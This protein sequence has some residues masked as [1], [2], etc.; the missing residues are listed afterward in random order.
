MS[1]KCIAEC[2]NKSKEL[3]L[4]NANKYGVMAAARHRKAIDKRYDYIFGRDACICALGMVASQDKRL[5]K[6]AKQSILTLAKYQTKLGE[7]PYSC[8]PSHNKSLFYYLGSIDSSLWWLIAVNF[9]DL[10]SGDKA[11]KSK[12]EKNI[13][14]AFKWLKYQD[15]NNCGLLEQCEASDWADDMPNNGMV[16]YTNV[17]WHKVLKI[18]G[19]KSEQ[20]LALD[21]LNSM[22]LP[23]EANPR[24]SRY[25]GQEIHRLKEFNI[26]K[27]E[28]EKVPYFLHYISY[29]YASDRCDIYANC[30]AILFEAANKIKTQEIIRFLRNA[31]VS[32]KHPVQAL[33]PPI[34]PQDYDWRPYMD[35]EECANK[36]YGY[37]NGG[38][39]PYIGAF[40]TMALKK[41]GKERLALSEL[42]R[43][44][45]LNKVNDWEFNEWF[46]GKTGQAMGMP[47][48]S[49]NAG[50]F[51]LAYHYLRGEINF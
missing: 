23:H 28:V 41:A 27:E 32:H 30:L 3:L 37:H 33:T 36:P 5:S 25:I 47:G 15:Q 6:I 44:A 24:R 34:D 4:A 17:L 50:T 10:Y 20:A 38:I 48:Q 19:S 7:I 40:W 18:Y 14:S 21:G 31:K 22:F 13:K 2:Y 42:E 51:L 29:K 9:Y 35:R 26:I 49:W 43:L 39:W 45:E 8:A 12:L 16:L 1:K 11:L 46:H